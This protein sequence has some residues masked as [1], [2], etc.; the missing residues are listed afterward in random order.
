M[1]LKEEIGPKLKSVMKVAKRSL[2]L[3]AHLLFFLLPLVNAFAQSITRAEYFFDTDPGVGS[4]TPLT[5]PSPSANVAFTSSISTASLAQGFHSLG[6]RVKESAGPWGHCESRSF[7]ITAAISDASNI[8]RAEYFFDA[9]PGAGNATSIPVAAGASV[10]FTVNLPTATLQPGF[11]FL[12]IRIK[13]AD[14]KWGIFEAR[15]FYVTSTTTDAAN[16]TKAEYFFDSDPGNGNGTAIPVTPGPTANFTVSLPTT[17]LPPG[18]HFLAIRTK[19]LDGKWGIF[20][21]RGFYI[22]GSTTD[23]PN[24]AGAEYFF[25]TDPGIGN[26]TPVSIPS[27]PTSSFTALIPVEALTPGFH[28]LGIR[29]KDFGGKWGI[30]ESRGFYISQATASSGDIVAAEYFFDTDPGEGNGFATTVSPVGP[31]INQIF[32]I[33]VTG[34]PSG[35]HKVGFR[36]QDSNGLWSEAQMRDFTV[37]TCTT[38]TA[39]VAPSVTR[40]NASAVSLS[41]TGATSGQVYRWYADG[42]VNTVLFTGSPFITPSLDATT[43]FFVSV[44][45]PT[46][47][48]ESAR[49]KVTA[50]VINVTKP[51][52][53]A[54]GTVVLCEGASFLLSAPSGFSSYSWSNGSTTEKILV[55]ANGDY[56]VTVGDGICT[57]V[58]SDVATFAFSPKPSKPIVQAS[59]PVK[60]CDGGTVTL[61]APAGFNYLW[62]NSAATQQITVST[63]GNFSVV[64]LD[65][66]GCSSESSDPVAVVASA[67]PAK[68]VVEIFGST[69]LC[70]TNT[71]GLLAPSGF[72]LYQW[73]NSQTLQGITV[74][75]AGAFTVA[76]GNEVNCLSPVSD[77]VTVT[78]TGQ[79][80]IGGAVNLPPTISTNPL[81]ANIEGKIVVDLTKIVSD[82]DGNIDFGTLRVVDNVTARGAPILV[83]TSL[84]VTIDYTGMPF[85]GVDKITIEVCDLSGACVQQVIDIDVVGAVQV[86]NGLSPDGDGHNDFMLIKYVDV[87]Q[88]A[89]NNHVTIFNR[90]GDVVWETANYNNSDRAFTG[91]NKKGSE[92]PS[93]TYFYR[94][95]FEGNIKTLTG[96]ITLIR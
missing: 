72:S 10:S 7:Y 1:R 9:D 29:A 4:A 57:S 44:F 91:L 94:I 59:G 85:T 84:E 82:P 26:A 79:P 15:G 37:L 68:P 78:S 67:R 53:N 48:C 73:S 81:S 92:L 64:V 62:S 70:G 6:L 56:S 89:A 88:G 50:V 5:I 80:C 86:F 90:W 63:T 55:T 39:P 93:G 41:A 77:V 35:A 69:V 31:T 18:F 75:S 30:F 11:H 36:V 22:T 12:A 34:V 61:T 25:D 43:D 33:A 13:G 66:A 87:V 76:V 42:T 14:G 16:I 54:N 95:A 71:V 49:T 21:T 74:T 38:P 60:L 65:G 2:L 20:E 83:T 45:D 24:I 52:L 47:L 51:L 40:C 23:S 46:T 58:P 8:T 19:G 17:N 3:I 27:G 28:F 32:P 96:F